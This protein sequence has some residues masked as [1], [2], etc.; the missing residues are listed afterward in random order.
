MK[1][2]FLITIII[3]L[4]F[5]IGIFQMSVHAEIDIEN[6]V[7]AWLFDEGK[8]TVAEDLSGNELNGTLEGKLNWVNG[9]FGKALEF[10]GT[11]AFIEIPAHE[12][13]R[14][15]I[16]ISIWVKSNT[17]NWNAHGW[18]VEKRNAFVLHP[19]QDS[20]NVA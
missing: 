4:S 12:N 18:F 10:N 19:N 16:T 7:G 11:D 8:G 6:V 20:K 2:C 14:E 13:P 3:C 17:D 5:S 15:Q 1:L 9:K